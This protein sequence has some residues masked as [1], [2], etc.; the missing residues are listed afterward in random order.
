MVIYLERGKG[1]SL[2]DGTLSALGFY[3]GYEES[4]PAHLMPVDFQLNP[5]PT[6][7]SIRDFMSVM[8][9]NFDRQSRFSVTE[10]GTVILHPNEDLMSIVHPCPGSVF[11]RAFV[12]VEDCLEESLMRCRH[13]KPRLGE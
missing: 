1:A 12:S 7:A 13:Q 10:G 5:V 3:F 11:W 8:G 6:P 4:L 2:E 9:I